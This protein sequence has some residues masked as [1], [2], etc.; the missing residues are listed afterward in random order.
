MSAGNEDYYKMFKGKQDDTEDIVFELRIPPD[1]VKTYFWV[2]MSILI[3]AVIGILTFL[4]AMFVNPIVGILFIVPSAFILLICYWA[5]TTH[6]SSY[7]K[8][9]FSVFGVKDKE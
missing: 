1:K 2:W 5:Q 6:K 4:P 3:T 7:Q 8:I 9:W